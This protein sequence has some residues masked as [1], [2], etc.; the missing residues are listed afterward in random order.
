LIR[1]ATA[2]RLR[3]T[4]L[5]IVALVGFLSAITATTAAIEGHPDA[6]VVIDK[7][8]RIVSVSTTGFAWRDGIRPNQIV[9]RRSDADS[10]T[11]WELFVIG[12]SGPVQSR[13][14]PVLEAL[15]GSLPFSIVGLAGGCLALAFLRLNRSWVLPSACLALAGA[16]VPLLLANQPSTATVLALSAAVPAIGVAAR[17]GHQRALAAAILIGSV[18]LVVAWYVAFLAGSGADAL[19]PARR[20][21][22]LGGTGI[23][24]TDR[25]MQRRPGSVTRLQTFSIAAAAAVVVGGLALVYFGGVPAPAIA[26]AI[27]LM[28][29]AAQPLWGTVGRRLE[30]A[31]LSDLRQQVAADVAEEERGRLAREL[32]DAPLQELSAVIRRLELVPGAQEATASLHAIADQLRGV[33]VDLRPPMLDDIGLASALDF[34]AEQVTTPGTVVTASI[35]DTCGLERARRPPE[36]VEFALYRIVREATANALR[37]AHAHEV[38]LEGRIAPDAVDVAVIDDG[39]GLEADTSS[40]ADGRGRLGISSMRRRAQAIGAE[41]AFDLGHA[42]GP[43]ARISVTWRA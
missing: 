17:F 13:E 26:I 37:H 35:V 12:A 39:I 18:A 6:G 41:L 34:L 27:V 24:M 32:H 10:A 29:L 14:A 1:A 25:A 5:A 23:L 28:L 15:R 19:E 9:V 22:A 2:Y 42:D 33:A 30:L 38:H 31:L 8:R 36:A 40:R 43:G 21:V 20:L 7:F 16:S 3:R 4:A 11:G